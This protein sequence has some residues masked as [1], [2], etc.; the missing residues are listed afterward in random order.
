MSTAR[1]QLLQRV[2][3]A[4]H[5]QC[6]RAEIDTLQL[7]AA[8][9]LFETRAEQIPLV[10]K[11]ADDAGITRIRGFADLVPLLF[12]HTTYKS[13]PQSFIDKGQWPRMQQ[14]LNALSVDDVMKVDLSGVVTVDDWVD[15]LWA[16]GHEV[17]AT[18]G[19]SGKCSF[20]NRN[21][22]DR[23]QV[24][25]YLGT[26]MGGFLGIA[27]H[28]DRPVFQLFPSSGPNYG[29]QTSRV[30]AELW[31]RPGEIHFLSDEPLRISQ[32]SRAAIMRRAMMEGT[33]TP[34]AI[35]E[36]EAEGL[37]KSAQ[38]K[39]RL[40]E[41][42]ERIMAHRHEPI[43]LS[44]QWGQHWTIVQKARAMG[45]G[46]GEFHPDSVVAAGGGIKGIPLPP[47]YEAQVNGF[48]GAVKRPKNYGMTEM[49]LMFPR[50]E[51]HH[52]H[53]PAGMIPLMLSGEGDQLL[54][55]EGRVEGR[56]GFVDLLFEGR[57][58]GVISGD[59][60]TMDFSEVCPCGRRGP[61]ILEPITRYAP[62][63]Q[64]DHIGCAGT[65]DAYIRGTI[66]A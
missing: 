8:Q 53:Q 25:R 31:G 20:L 61:T 21:A 4:D 46:D 44:G 57:W 24:R 58:G 17:M 32:V 11:R 65:I 56:F 5:Y 39:G 26:V 60:L 59:K 22:H 9:E 23:E 14:W 66:E 51:A 18:S 45:I 47:D 29:V 43:F 37:A 13:Y 42:I 10:K 63:G 3:A 19:T 34:T 48:Y 40:V 28:A 12:P 27:P 30:N 49:A 35:A 62:P 6:A 52:Y 50:C 54:P 36:F 55:R 33:A 2:Y 64:D 7:L 41:M 16:N 1:D 15:R 38:M